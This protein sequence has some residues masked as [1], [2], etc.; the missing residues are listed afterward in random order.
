MNSNEFVSIH[1]DVPVYKFGVDEIPEEEEEPFQSEIDGEIDETIQE[2]PN[3]YRIPYTNEIFLKGH[4]KTVSALSLDPVGN[5][6]LTGSYD[7]FVKFWD[8]SSMDASFKSFR[9]VE[10]FEGYVV[11]KLRYSRRGDC[12][13]VAS[14]SPHMKLFDRD[15]RELAEFEKGYQYISDKDHTNGHTTEVTDLHWHPYNY[16]MFL[17]CSLD[18]TIRIWNID[19][20]KK[21]ETVIK[22]KNDRGLNQA[23]VFAFNV[24]KEYKYIICGTSDGTLHL[25]DTKSKFLRAKHRI[26]KAHQAGCDISCISISED[27][28]TVISRA[29]DHTLKV[30]DV[31]S[32]KKPVKEFDNLPN[33]FRE[34]SCLFDPNDRLIV[35]GTSRI[36]D[37]DVGQLVFIDKYE[38]EVV[39]KLDI[40]AESVV[41]VLWHPNINQIICGCSDNQ[42]H[43]LFDEH[44]STKGVLECVQKAP[45]RKLD[46]GYRPE[47]YSLETSDNLFMKP[48][49]TPE[50][51]LRRLLRKETTRANKPEAPMQGG[52]G[53]GGH[54]GSSLKA[55][56]MKKL[57]KKID[58]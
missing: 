26:P 58:E 21:Q 56:I 38:L 15:G 51:K 17:S 22:V 14:T 29:T 32:F 45:R 35:T 33:K 41:S 48:E 8:F 13:L 3:I 30:W 31:R 46:F 16:D 10:P 49:P 53:Y 19:N 2:D 1:K 47:V 55:E 28:N 24:D 34:T 52:P 27:G 37:N 43:I 9:E 42:T 18:S 11:N 5:R 7:C 6:L 4:A 12:F 39:K 44:L 36:E 50:T 54:L 23:P 57:L 40:T 20:P 25:Y